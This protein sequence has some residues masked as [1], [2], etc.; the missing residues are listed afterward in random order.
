VNDQ[1]AQI[2]RIVRQV[3]A[4]LGVVDSPTVPVAARNGKPAREADSQY[5][6]PSKAPA[7][8]VIGDRVV[9]LASLDGRLNGA[10]VLRVARGAVVTP[11]VRDELKTRNIRLEFAEGPSAN[12]TKNHVE[13]VLGIADTPEDVSAATSAVQGHLTGLANVQS[14]QHAD[15][16]TL[17]GRIGEAI[18]TRCSLAVIWSRRPAA[19]ACLANRLRGVRAVWACTPK[20]LREAMATIA[21]NILTYNP[22]DHAAFAQRAMLQE[23]IR[24]GVQ[25]CPDGLREH[26]D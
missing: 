20:A 1:T 14:M 7:D 23:F 18:E 11:A 19:A 24:A 21:P 5:G 12:P 4:E 13:L 2:E 6:E 26:L 9:T 16:G 8:C 17:V 22:A 25:D 3:L 10:R 15:L